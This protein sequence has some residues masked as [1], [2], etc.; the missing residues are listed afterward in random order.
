MAIQH[1]SPDTDI[2]VI[3]DIIERDAAVVIDD[4]LT[5]KDLDEFHLVKT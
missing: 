3:L 4:V 2:G 5:K 1:V